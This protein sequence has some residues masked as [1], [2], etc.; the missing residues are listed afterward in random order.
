MDNFI[1]KYIYNNSMFT[2]K[3][4]KKNQILFNEGEICDKIFFVIDGCV[5]IKTYTYNEKEEI[6][7]VLKEN[8]W[9]GDVLAFTDDKKYLGIGICKS[10]SIIAYIT[11]SSLLK[12]CKDEDFLRY[13]LKNICNKTIQIKKQNKL[14]CHKNIRD[15]ILHYFEEKMIETKSRTIT[16]TS[17]N[18]LSNILSLPRPSV[19]RELKNMV[20]DGIINKEKNIITLL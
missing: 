16:L 3:K 5:E 7:T 19:S 2:I 1:N 9:F 15:R 13:Y 14:L 6:I 11:S 17:I 12:L 8:E 20:D 18:D 4:Y 10:N